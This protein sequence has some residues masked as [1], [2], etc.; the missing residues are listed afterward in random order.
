MQTIRFSTSTNPDWH[1]LQTLVKADSQHPYIHRIDMPYRL[2]STWQDQGCKVGMWESDGKLFTWA[3]FLPS[4][5]NL[6][7][8]LHPAKR[9]TT[10]ESEVFAWG[11]EQ[12]TNYAKRVN[13]DFYGS[14]EI[15]VKL[16]RAAFKSNNMTTTWRMQTLEHPDYK[17][18][19]DLVVADSDDKPVPVFAYVGNAKTGTG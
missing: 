13:D 8:A 10:L 4:W 1:Y 15:Y 19:L 12:M 7:Y 9:G 6:D 16:H 2:T 18:E 3:V 14:V 17:P 11:K 5:W